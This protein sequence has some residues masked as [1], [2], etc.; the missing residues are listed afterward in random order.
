L[1]T[2]WAN[3]ETSIGAVARIRRFNMDVEPEEKQPQPSPYPN[4]PS[5]GGIELQHVSASYRF[6]PPSEP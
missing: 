3:L 4:W 5:Q 2:F 6:V 1:I